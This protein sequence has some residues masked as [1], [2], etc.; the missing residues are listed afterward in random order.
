VMRADDARVYGPVFT[1]GRRAERLLSEDH[2][3][4]TRTVLRGALDSEAAH[5]AFGER[6]FSATELET[7]LECPY[8]WFYTRVLRPSDDDA[9]LDAAELGSR[10]HRL[11]ADFY[12][13]LRAEGE[14]RVTPESLPE[15]LRLFERSAEQSERR[16]ALPLSL[17][18]EIDVGRARLWARHVVE[19][20][21]HLLRGYAPHGH[22]I[23]FGGEGEF[24][25]AGIPMVGRIDRIDVGPGGV[26]VSDY[27]SAPD[28]GKLTRPGASFSMQHVIY[29][30]AA[31]QLLGLPVQGSVYRSLRSRQLRGFWRRDLLKSVP[32]EAC[33]KDVIGEDGFSELS[34]M[35]A[36]RV[37]AAAEGIR[38]GRIP[39]SGHSAASCRYCDL[40]PLCEGAR[41]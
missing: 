3:P 27:K 39:R 5:R 34:E 28:V 20:D 23:S 40:A 37:L 32:A 11:L 13:A 12:A 8:R 18:E 35:A 21:A 2:L 25:F 29:A 24:E 38:A 4:T 22:E 9:E 30:A 33:G 6:V 31:E 16:M 15:A 14:T 17:G 26:V 10:A 41:S 19:D 7:Y 1:Q 36:E